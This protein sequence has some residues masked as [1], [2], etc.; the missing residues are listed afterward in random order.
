MNYNELKKLIGLK[1]EAITL[2]NKIFNLVTFL[3]FVAM[4]I[5]FMSNLYLGLNSTLNWLV[6]ALLAIS[7]VFFYLSRYK[8]MY[9]KV[10]G[11]YILFC[12]LFYVPVWFTNGGIEGPTIV[13]YSLILTIAMLILP[14]KYHSP[15][16]G[17]TIAIIMLLIYTEQQHPEWVVSYP[18]EQIRQI[19]LVL[20]IFLYFGI[21]GVTASLYKRTYDMDRDDLIKKSID[22]EES[23]EYL[24]ETKMQ[25]EEATRAKSRFL[26]NMSHEIRTPLNGIIGTIDL[27]HHTPLSSEQ[28]ELMQ[29]LKSSST[30]LLEIVNDVL[31]ISKIEADK[32]ELFEGPCNLDAIIKNVISISSPRI[33][34]LKKELRIAYTIDPKTELE[35][36]ADESR[37]KQILINLVSNAIKF[38]ETGSVKIEIGSLPIDESIQELNFAVVDTGIGISEEHMRTLFIPFTQ[39]D[40]SATRK[41]SGTGLGLSICRKI[42]EEMGGRIWIESELGK[43]SAFRFIIPVQINL[44][45]K[46]HSRG[47]ENTT[48]PAGNGI[49]KS[50]KLLVAE[51]NGMNQ[52]LAKKMFSKIGYDIEIAHNGKEAF[53]KALANNYDFIFMDIHMP[54][55]DGLE[56]TVHILNSPLEKVPVIIAMTANVV[57]EAEEDCLESGMKDIITKPFTIEQLRR[58]L[59]K[60][61]S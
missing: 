27:M 10:S 52:L 13:A 31:D 34:A 61:T 3:V 9:K 35:I 20:T 21:I 38:T 56:A 29:S 19:D 17:V 44:V 51:D 7:F 12:H 50:L 26:A 6:F 30:L 2:E 14:K 48:K 11:W 39:I 33:T 28:E 47:T 43:G 60:W 54:E 36:I 40:N 49:Q 37:I 45:K 23:R 16:I 53:E 41:H 55:M 25:A 32:L 22:L 46:T 1:K 8:D 4:S 15:F 58:V 24:S 57:K 18:S 5:S 42:I 59:D